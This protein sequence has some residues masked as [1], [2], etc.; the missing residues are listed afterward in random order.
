M[1][2]CDA[3]DVN[4]KVFVTG[5][6]GFIGTR[7]VGVLAER[8]HSVRVL[9]RRDA[10]AP[11]PGVEPGESPLG[12]ERVELVRGDITDA[13]SLRRGMEGC[14]YVFHLAAY[15]KNWAKDPK[16]FFDVNVQG[17]RNVF[18][19]AEELGVQRV[20]WTSTFVT[21]GP[22]R[23]GM[24]GDEAMPRITD[25]YFNDY[26][27]T[28][29]IAEREAVARA[30]KGF[31]VVIV[32]PTRVYGPGHLTEGNT[33][34]LLIDQYDRG[35]LPLLLNAGMNVSNY[36]L[37]DDVVEG[38]LLAMDRGR[39][40]E[41]YILGGKNVSLKEFLSVIDRITGRRHFQIPIWRIAPT[42]FAYFLKKRAE[43]FGVYPRITPGWVRMFMADWAYSCDKAQRELG[44]RPTPLDVG[45]RSTVEW[46]RRIRDAKP[47]PV[48]ADRQVTSR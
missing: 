7:L 40:G 22:T 29:T 46:I 44:Y 31:P 12:H 35:R 8:G 23:P 21:F 5:G 17:M 33:L 19:T 48:V 45:L 1:V 38:H 2:E 6:T 14:R 16:T 32:N 39:L 20:V 47:R 34:S 30:E 43:W 11:P 42:V 9:S 24:V 15:A 36:V 37:V 18:D 26:Q 3:M 4:E 13:D 28:K 10:P 41:R 27:R 25:K